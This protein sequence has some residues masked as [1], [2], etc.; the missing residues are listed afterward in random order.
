V[1]YRSVY[2][3]A[4]WHTSS[5][6]H[7]RPQV[8]FNLLVML[9]M[10]LREVIGKCLQIVIATVNVRVCINSVC[11]KNESEP[12]ILL[13]RNLFAFDEFYKFLKV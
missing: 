2:N 12:D 10:P 3:P 4:E 11:R 6:C 1:E 9:V 5:F 7:Q 13:T 8:K